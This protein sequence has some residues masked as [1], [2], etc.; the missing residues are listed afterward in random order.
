[1][2]FFIS[3]HIYRPDYYGRPTS[4]KPTDGPKTT[5]VPQPVP[6]GNPQTNTPTPTQLQQPQQQDRPESSTPTAPSGVSNPNGP[7]RPNPQRP[8]R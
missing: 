3:P 8:E 4:A 6:L 1:M 2:L 5:S 7:A